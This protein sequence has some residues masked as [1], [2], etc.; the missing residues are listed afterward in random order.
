MTIINPVTFA[1]NT[2][3]GDITSQINHVTRNIDKLMTQLIS[4]KAGTSSD[5]NTQELQK[6]ES[7]ISQLQTQKIQ[8][9]HRKI[10]AITQQKQQESS[11]GS[12]SESRSIEASGRKTGIYI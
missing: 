11:E 4:V 5:A 2:A 6:I 3:E 9:E 1:N 8:L 10:N 12:D 7:Q